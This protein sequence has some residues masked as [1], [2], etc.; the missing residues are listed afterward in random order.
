MY[1]R[2]EFED[3]TNDK[4]NATMQQLYGSPSGT[5]LCSMNSINMTSKK[6]RDAKNLSVGFWYLDVNILNKHY[7]GVLSALSHIKSYYGVKSVDVIPINS[8]RPVSEEEWNQIQKELEKY[9][10]CSYL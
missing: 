7:F 3:L 9:M 10:D 4:T 6:V 5:C 2:V 1:I 8:T